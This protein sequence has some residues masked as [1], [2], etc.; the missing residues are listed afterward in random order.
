MKALELGMKTLKLCKVCMI[1]LELHMKALK[2]CMIALE[3]HMKAIKLCSLKL[4]MKALLG[5]DQL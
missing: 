5:V 4:C 2:L 3:L 1:A